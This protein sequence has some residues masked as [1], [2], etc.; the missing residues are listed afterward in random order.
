MNAGN[1][2]L[3][4]SIL[5]KP[6]TADTSVTNFLLLWPNLPRQKLSAINCPING[7][8]STLISPAE[9]YNKINNL[10]TIVVQVKI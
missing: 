6:T 9:K 7:M 8:Q 4:N 5:R 2:F 10:K 1:G 3:Q